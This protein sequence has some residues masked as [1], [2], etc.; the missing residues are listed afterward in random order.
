MRRLRLPT[1]I[2]VCLLLVFP[3][4]K[5]GIGNWFASSSYGKKQI[6]LADGTK[7]YVI[8][9]LW[10]HRERLYITRDSDG[11]KPGDAKTDYLG[12]VDAWSI[13]L[14]KV[15]PDG[16]S[17]YSDISPRETVAP[18]QGWSQAKPTVVVAKD[19]GIEDLYKDRDRYG[20]SAINVPLNEICLINVFRVENSLR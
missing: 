8:R 7:V 1:L 10:G 6:V 5:L 14:Y 4:A 12:P 18:T 2:L 13:L 17:V 15:Q 11:C 9:E 19:P 16:W 20:I 3:F